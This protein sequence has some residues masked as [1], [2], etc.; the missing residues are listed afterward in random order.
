MRVLGE[1][2]VDAECPLLGKT[3]HTGTLAK[4][5]RELSMQRHRDSSAPV[6]RDGQLLE[7]R[8]KALGALRK[9]RTR[10]S[11]LKSVY[12]HERDREGPNVGVSD[13]CP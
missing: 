8:A 7:S 6:A 11:G 9:G 13:V 4:K 5:V 1:G 12:G 10:E 2:K 3:F